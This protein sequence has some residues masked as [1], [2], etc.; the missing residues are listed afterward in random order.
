MLAE[1]MKR[2][3]ADAPSGWR[4]DLLSGYRRG[5]WSVS[6]SENWRVTFEGDDGYIDRLN[7]EDYH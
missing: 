3:T 2:F 4:V 7:L 1:D 6:V 5:M